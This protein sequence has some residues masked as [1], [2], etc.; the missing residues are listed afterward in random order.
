[1]LVLKSPSPSLLGVSALADAWLHSLGVRE[2]RA[3]CISQS[4]SSDLPWLPLSF[5][6]VGE[7]SF[8]HAEISIQGPEL[9]LLL[10]S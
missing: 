7:S 9:H 5:R 8:T 2:V 3:P 6:S 4:L 1:M 10:V